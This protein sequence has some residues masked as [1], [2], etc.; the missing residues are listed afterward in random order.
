M[1]VFVRF[2]VAERDDRSNQQRGIFTA[3]YDLEEK[4]LLEPHELTWFREL[5]TW[6]DRHLAQ[7][8]R[9]AWS[10]RP[11]A[12][13]RAITWLRMT[14]GEHLRNMRQLVTLLEHKGV[15]V[16]EL[17]TDKPGY[18]VYEDAH[19]VAAIPFPNETF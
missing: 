6:F 2:V 5:D 4:G 18:V 19:Q 10:A 15:L 3:L 16:E 8:E 9:L 17:R 7:P 12:P 11:N 13:E 1:S 14:A